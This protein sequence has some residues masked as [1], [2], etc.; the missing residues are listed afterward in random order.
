[1]PTQ[2]KNYPPEPAAPET[3]GQRVDRLLKERGVTLRQ[4]SL[5]AGM[6]EGWLKGLVKGRS[7]AMGSDALASLAA[8]LGVGVEVLAGTSGTTKSVAKVLLD[9]EHSADHAEF[10]WLMDAA[11]PKSPDLRQAQGSPSWAVSQE[12]FPRLTHADPGEVVTYQM[13]GDSM[14]PAILAGQRV[15]VDL[16]DCK[17]SPPG[18]FVVWDGLGHRVVRVEYLP[19][20]GR[21]ARFAP[22]N[23]AYSA[24]EAEIDGEV[25][26]LGRV[27]GRWA[28]M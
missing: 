23:P 28:R 25:K 7:K 14:E 16:S 8:V 10:I 11:R 15:L 1:M 24:F 13:D 27:I 3:L 26:I 4:A 17:P 2:E 5:Q 6:S 18:T 12:E 19:E 21:R 22:A 9:G 20:T